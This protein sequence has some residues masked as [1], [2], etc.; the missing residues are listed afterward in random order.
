M[1]NRQ[2]IRIKR[3]LNDLGFKFN[4]IYKF[5]KQKFA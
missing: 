5:R 3:S 1:D 4:L 2:T